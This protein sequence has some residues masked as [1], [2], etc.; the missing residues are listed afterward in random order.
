[1][2]YRVRQTLEKKSIIPLFNIIYI[3]HETEGIHFKG[4]FV[5]T[6]AANLC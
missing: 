2:T 1:M 4:N 6:I 5:F 3:K